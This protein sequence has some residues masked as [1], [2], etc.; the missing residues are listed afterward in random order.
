MPVRH[1]RLGTCLWCGNVPPRY[2]TTSEHL[3]PR[4]VVRAFRHF[5]Q[6]QNLYTACKSCNERRGPMPAALYASIRKD[7]GALDK[8]NV[9]WHSIAQILGQGKG[10]I[11]LREKTLVAFAAM[12]PDE[13]GLRDPRVGVWPIN[14]VRLCP[15]APSQAEWI[16][17]AR[18]YDHIGMRREAVALLPLPAWNY[19]GAPISVGTVN[20]PHSKNPPIKRI[21]DLRL[22]N[23]TRTDEEAG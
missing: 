7:A 17:I 3:V 21:Y 15:R 20:P 10:S 13:T 23:P 16:K 9:Y 12:I 11:E 1:A 4:W 18:E 14:L 6:I 2:K 19:T 8:S 22:A 5:H